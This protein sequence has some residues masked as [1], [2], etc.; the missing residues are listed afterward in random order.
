[1]RAQPPPQLGA[2]AT[3]HT[4][5]HTRT[6]TRRARRNTNAVQEINTAIKTLWAAAYKGSDIEEIMIQSDEDAGGDDEGGGGGGGGGA[7]AATARTSRNYNYRVVMRKGEALIDM[8]GRC[9]A[10]Q[11]V[12]ASIVI[13]LALAESFCVHTCVLLLPRE[14]VRPLIDTYPRTPPPHTPPPPQRHP[15]AG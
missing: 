15:R 1:L 9:S 12:L 4:L 2:H 11:K 7:P 5:T 14:V 6:H 3:R 10:G 13:R 8:R